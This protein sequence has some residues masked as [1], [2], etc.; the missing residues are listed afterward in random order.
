MKTD[1]LVQIPGE[2]PALFLY[3]W[4]VVPLQNELVFEK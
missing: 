3:V 1:T 4:L 2:G